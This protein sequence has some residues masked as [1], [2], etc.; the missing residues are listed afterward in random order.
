MTLQAISKRTLIELNEPE[1]TVGP[2]DPESKG[3]LTNDQ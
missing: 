1:T 3:T 2:V